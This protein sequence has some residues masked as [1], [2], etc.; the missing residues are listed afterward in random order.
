ML[1]KMKNKDGDT[2]DD[3]QNVEKLPRKKIDRKYLKIGIVAF[4]VI[5]CSVVFYFACFDTNA[6]FNFVAKIGN[7]IEPFAVGAVLAYV[8]KPMCVMYEKLVSKWFKNAK[9]KHKAEKAV[10]NISICF[11]MITFFAIIYIMFA[12]ILPQFFDSVKE[13]VNKAPELFENLM[14][15]LRRIAGNEESIHKALDTFYASALDIIDIAVAE[16]MDMDVDIIFSSAVTGVK[17]LIQ[18]LTNVLVGLIAAV[19]ILAQ[20]K[21]FAKQGKMIVYSVFKEKWAEKILDEFVYIDK[22]FS[23]FIN[24][25]IVDSI[26]IGILTFIVLSIFKM[27]YTLLVSVIVGVTNI[28]PYF[29]P[30]I[31]AIPSAFI[32]LMIDPIKGLQFIIII[33]IIQ[34]LDGNIIGPKI[35]GD[36][37]GVS[38]FWVLFAILLFGGLFGFM[39]MLLGVPLFAVIYDIIRRLIRHG[40]YK[41]KK[42]DIYLE[43]EKEQDEIEEELADKKRIKIFKVKRRK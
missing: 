16:I 31:G 36:S 5:V 23:G 17:S 22:M 9:K 28:I 8:L 27:P 4:L 42:E 14:A 30:F 6:L 15:W 29:G 34:Q 25:K 10:T 19:Y 39:G 38:S 41:N 24:G 40:L 7:A 20:R 35:L 12:A 1:L 18:I 32:I 43:Y 11:T 26:I 2:M 21:K 13:L 3:N 37:T 33:I